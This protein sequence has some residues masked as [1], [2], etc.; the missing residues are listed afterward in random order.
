MSR[1]ICDMCVHVCGLCT[2]VRDSC[3]MTLVT[4]M[5]QLHVCGSYMYVADSCYIH[6]DYVHMYIYM[7]LIIY[8]YVDYVYMSR[9]ICDMYIVHIHVHSAHT[10]FQATC[11]YMSLETMYVD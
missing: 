8:M 6:V 1:I 5:W 9:I 10:L 4:C 11:I 2:Y 7:S 3:Y